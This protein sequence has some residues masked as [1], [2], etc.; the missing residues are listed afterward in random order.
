M[1]Q[2]VPCIIA[3]KVTNQGLEVSDD[4][5]AVLLCLLQVVKQP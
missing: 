2:Q 4:Q 5:T 1:V 3:K